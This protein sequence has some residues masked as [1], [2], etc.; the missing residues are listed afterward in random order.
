VMNAANEVAV[1]A[2]LG[3]R[4]RFGDVFRVVSETLNRC[5]AVRSVVPESLDALLA[6]DQEA[7]RFASNLLKTLKTFS[8]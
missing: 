6:I 8:A 3:E 7:R 4:I 2:F 5:P 1:D